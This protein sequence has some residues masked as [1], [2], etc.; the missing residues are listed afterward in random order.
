M[1]DPRRLRRAAGITDKVCDDCR[2]L[3]DFSPDGRRLLFADR[4]ADANAPNRIALFDLVSGEKSR[5]IE[6]PTH[7]LFSPRFSP[8]GRWVSFQEFTGLAS[9]RIYAAPLRGNAAVPARDWVPITDGTGLDRDA[10][11]APDGNLLYFFSERDGFPCIGRSGWS[12]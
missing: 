1:A 4:P 5:L 10:A 6:H 12:L 3:N 9:R 7:T 11:W 8:D 2:G